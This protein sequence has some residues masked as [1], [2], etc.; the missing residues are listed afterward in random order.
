MLMEGDTHLFPKVCKTQNIAMPP[1]ESNEGLESICRGL[2]LI[3]G[4]AYLHVTLSTLSPLIGFYLLLFL[5]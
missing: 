2:N 4:A 1:G 5:G 3:H